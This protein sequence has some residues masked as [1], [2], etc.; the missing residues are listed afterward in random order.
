MDTFVILSG[1]E[2]FDSNSSRAGCLDLLKGIPFEAF[3]IYASS[4]C[5]NLTYL[6]ALYST[7]KDLEGFHRRFLKHILPEA[8]MASFL[9]RIENRESYRDKM[10]ALSDQHRVLKL[11]EL[12]AVAN[13]S[14]PHGE[15]TKLDLAKLVH[16]Q[17]MIN[18]LVSQPPSESIERMSESDLLGMFSMSRDWDIRSTLPRAFE[19]YCE[20]LAEKVPGLEQAFL[21]K[22]GHNIASFVTVLYSLSN[23]LMI[24]LEDDESGTV[25]KR[26]RFLDGMLD[27]SSISRSYPDGALFLDVVDRH[28]VYWET[29][30][31][32]GQDASVSEATIRPFLRSPFVRTIEGE[33]W[34]PDPGLLLSAATNGLFWLAKEAIEATGRNSD[35]LFRAQGEAFEEYIHGFFDRVG[36]CFHRGDH[37]GCGLPDFFIIE[38]DC[39]VVLEAKANVMT[40]RAKWSSDSL[41]L[42][43]QLDKISNDNQLMKA[44]ARLFEQ[45][46]DLIAGV[47]RVIPVI[48]T[49]DPSFSS[50][51]LERLVNDKVSKP[52]ICCI[53]DDIQLLNISNLEISGNYIK[54]GLFSK[55]LDARR[56]II[57]EHGW[58]PL[59]TV[60]NRFSE[61]V[62]R[63]TEMHHDFFDAHVESRTRLSAEMRRTEETYKPDQETCE[64]R[65]S[66]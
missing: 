3:S 63:H 34:C 7:A 50:P 24:S 26:L 28:S 44:T 6:D 53:V 65:S 13:P 43:E 17:L 60:I 12:Y 36:A 11:V 42:Q 15:A 23:H 41:D 51:G 57:A 59:G 19:L 35:E 9:D 30:C 40:D 52:E 8:E 39:L 62:V 56:E 38:S 2:I 10:W 33:T 47:Q 25:A 18:D 48:V 49:L 32:T 45:R 21:S 22:F 1:N 55:L 58:M 66:D 5:Y 64:E 61:S 54:D 16:A 29:L 27:T 46:P 37:E 4:L 31:S 14:P 20:R